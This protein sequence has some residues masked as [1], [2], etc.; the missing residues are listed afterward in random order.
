MARWRGSC[1]KSLRVAAL[2][3]MAAGLVVLVCNLPGWFWGSA[4]GILLISVGFLLWR[5][6]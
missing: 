5:F 6:F 2:A 3:L 1:G 4:L